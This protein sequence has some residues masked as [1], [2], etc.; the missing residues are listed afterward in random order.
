M[1]I[2]MTVTCDLVK[3]LW[4]N[5]KNARYPN[6]KIKYSLLKQKKAMGKVPQNS[7]LGTLL[8]ILMVGIS[9]DNMFVKLNFIWIPSLHCSFRGVI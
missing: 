3:L 7:S 5:G 1:N 2:E 8:C 6:T 9:K 4:H